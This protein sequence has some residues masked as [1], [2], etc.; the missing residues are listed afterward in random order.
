MSVKGHG[1]NAGVTNMVGRPKS[2]SIGYNGNRNAPYIINYNR[3]SVTTH[4]AQGLFRKLT[5]RV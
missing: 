2:A 1:S 3:N 4:K 5:G